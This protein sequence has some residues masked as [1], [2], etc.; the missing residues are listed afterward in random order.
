[1]ALYQDI[2]KV[3]GLT[4]TWQQRNAQLYKMLGS[5]MG[6]Y[7]GSYDQN[8]YLI[9]QLNKNN[10]YS[11]GLPGQT[12]T[13][14]TSSSSATTTTPQQGILDAGTANL[15]PNTD[16]YSQDVNT[17]ESW[18][19]PFDEW[20]RNYVDTYMRPEWERDTYTP[21]MQQMTQALN[22]TN[23]SMGAS[24]AWRTGTARKNLADMAKDM[25]L[26]EQR[27]RE[28]F[29]DETVQT[30]DKIRSSLAVPLYSADMQRW[31]DTPWRNLNTEGVDVAGAAT[32]AGISGNPLNDLITS[33]PTWTPNQQ[34]TLTPMDWTVKPNSQYSPNLFKDYVGNRY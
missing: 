22:D 7:T 12:K 4:G 2:M 31:G 17:Q 18:Y 21:K 13:A 28:D 33:L 26:E 30:R 24:G 27:M 9:N 32:S 1:M 3:P 6:G 11:G 10:F 34:S 8:M 16:I 5:P 15:K 23:Q 19:R 14:S 25:T 29:Q 20:T